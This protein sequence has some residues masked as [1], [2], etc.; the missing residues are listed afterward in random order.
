MNI[1]HVWLAPSDQDPAIHYWYQLVG[2]ILPHRLCDGAMGAIEIAEQFGEVCQSC[3]ATYLTD[4]HH[5]H[6]VFRLVD[7][8]V[9]RRSSHLHLKPDYDTLPLWSA[10]GDFDALGVEDMPF[11]STTMSGFRM[12]CEAA[13][14][15][16]DDAAR[17]L[18]EGRGGNPLHRGLINLFRNEHWEEGKDLANLK[19]ALPIFLEKWKSPGDRESGKVIADDYIAFIEGRPYPTDWTRLLPGSIDVGGLSIKVD[20]EVVVATNGRQPQALKLWMSE[21]QPGENSLWVVHYLMEQVQKYSAYALG[22][23]DVRRRDV[24][25]I[26]IP[27][28]FG[29]EV[30]DQAQQLLRLWKKLFGDPD[31]LL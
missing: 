22:V 18:K 12:F 7:L 13:D 28:D 11:G 15:K 5:G 23:L 1:L 20:P 27:P 29:K 14:D 19:E 21:H 2:N 8:P 17:R 26:R 16:K 24:P 31:R 4:L 3:R 10:S 6:Q 9:P 30:E 25:D